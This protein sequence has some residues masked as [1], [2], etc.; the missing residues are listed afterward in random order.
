MPTSIYL[1]KIIAEYDT[2]GDVQARE[3][4]I[5]LENYI[6]FYVSPEELSRLH[7]HISALADTLKTVIGLAAEKEGGKA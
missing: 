1:D 7:T 3:C 6:E 2:R 4:I 5:L